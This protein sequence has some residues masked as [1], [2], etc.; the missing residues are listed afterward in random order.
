[1]K[2]VSCGPCEA[3]TPTH[4]LMLEASLE[5]TAKTWP[6]QPSMS[7]RYERILGYPDEMLLVVMQLPSLEGGLVAPRLGSI[8][9]TASNHNAASRPLTMMARPCF[10]IHHSTSGV[11]DGGR[12]SGVMA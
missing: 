11:V 1:M 3:D 7:C 4:P 8:T 10:L 5:D 12:Y 2:S 6:S 9:I